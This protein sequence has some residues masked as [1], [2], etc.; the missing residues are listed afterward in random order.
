MVPKLDHKKMAKEIDGVAYMWR[1]HLKAFILRTH[2]HVN[3]LRT[4]R[5]LQLSLPFFTG[6]E[7]YLLNT[8]IS[9]LESGDHDKINAALECAFRNRNVSRVIVQNFTSRY[10]WFWHISA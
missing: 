7:A 4:T 1:W 6:H 5:L 10:D 9:A 3:A 2:D 8:V